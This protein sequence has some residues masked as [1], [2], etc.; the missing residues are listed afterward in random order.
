MARHS[1][2]PD[3]DASQLVVLTPGLSE[4]EIA[5]VT[6]VLTAALREQAARAE[7]AVNVSQSAWPR[8][9][10][11]PRPLVRGEGAWRSWL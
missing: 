9:Q 6:A 11:A 4:D 10:R 8:S 3:L 5:A 2:Q 7:P 1:A